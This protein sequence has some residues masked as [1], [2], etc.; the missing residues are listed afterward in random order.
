MDKCIPDPCSGA[1]YLYRTI[2]YLF[3][4]GRLLR[5]SP[6]RKTLAVLEYLSFSRE[7]FLDHLSSLEMRNHFRCLRC[8]FRWPLVLILAQ[9]DLIVKQLQRKEVT[10]HTTLQLRPIACACV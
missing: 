1:F 3:N 5:S 2:Q 10:L 4:F 6:S 8:S 7:L 9:G